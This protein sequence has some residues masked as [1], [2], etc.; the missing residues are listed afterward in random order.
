LASQHSETQRR[1]R[2][3]SEHVEVERLVRAEVLAPLAERGVQLV[4]A[5][6]P[7]T[8]KNAVRIVG[9]ARA[10]GVEVALWPM[11]DDAHGRWA[12]AA[13]AERWCAFVEAL[14]D[15]LASADALPD[16][17]CIDLE[18]PIALVRGWSA[19]R[20]R[21]AAVTG[22]RRAAAH[23]FT[24][25][26]ARARARGVQTW[27]AAVPLVLADAAGLGFWQHVLGTPVDDLPLANV[28]VM[29]YSS[30]VGY[31]RGL[32]RRD[33]AEALVWLGARACRRRW[34][35]RAAV[36]L[37]AVGVGAL[38]DEPI[39][40]DV[41]ELLV[42]VGLARAAGIEDLALFD[43]GGALARAPLERWLDALCHG[44]PAD[45]PPRLSKRVRALAGI[46]AGLAKVGGLALA[47]RIAPVDDDGPVRP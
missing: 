35:G 6:R 34:D 25:T 18:P 31:A 43:L 37:G 4:A 41:D 39:Y 30:L 8:A 40:A 32:L 36:G 24:R 38:G 1:R 21:R 9:Q 17:L 26:L 14:L 2:V 16:E 45:D 42:D 11:I 46:T 23:A 20:P 15:D 10:A 33:H 7:D 44:P 29:L 5:V 12:S 3:F 28:C 19:V 22:D 13:S 47:G 27:A